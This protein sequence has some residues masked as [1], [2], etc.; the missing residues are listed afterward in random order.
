MMKST[1]LMLIVTL[2]CLAPVG[3]KQQA[4][5]SADATATATATETATATKTAKV[6]KTVIYSVKGMSC[7]GCASAIVTKLDKMDGVV[8]CDVSLEGQKAT[9]EL[10]GNGS[11]TDVEE[12]IRSLGYTVEPEPTNPAS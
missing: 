11:A 6:E 2:G 12:A 1:T 4:Q 10:A 5:P 3:C 8:K 7:G 9:V